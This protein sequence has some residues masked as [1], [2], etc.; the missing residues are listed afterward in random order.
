M[1]IVIK[2]TKVF[3]LALG[4]AICIIRYEGIGHAVIIFWHTL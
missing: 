2:G 3:G 1:C 4:Y